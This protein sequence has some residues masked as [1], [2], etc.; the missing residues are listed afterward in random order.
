MNLIKGKSYSRKEISKTLGG[1]G[2]SYLPI[3]DGQI[4]CGC[5]KKD[6]N[7]DAPEEV[8]IGDINRKSAEIISEQEEP[9]PVFIKKDTDVWEYVGDYKCVD[10][11]IKPTLL[12][13]KEKQYPERGKITA[14]LKFKKVMFSN[15]GASSWLYPIAERTKRYFT[16]DDG[17]TEYVSFSSFSEAI[18]NQKFPKDNWWG[19]GQN[20]SKVKVGDEV[21]IYI[22]DENKGIVGYALVKGKQGSNKDTWKLCLNFDLDKCEQLIQKPISAKIVR[23]WIQGRIKTVNNLDTVL[24]KLEKELPWL[25]LPIFTAI[26]IDYPNPPGRVTS[27]ITRVIRDTKESKKL[28]KLYSDKCQ[29]CHTTLNLFGRNYSEA[30]HLQPLGKA[31]QGPDIQGNMLIVCP[32]HHAQLD[33]GAITIDPDTFEIAH[34]N[35]S[36]LGKL[37]VLPNHKLNK[38]YLKY[39]LDFY[40]KK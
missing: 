18:K 6:L 27:K 24:S 35:G 20:F 22:G 15:S 36:K 17:S 40:T 12:R 9:I 1:S 34:K 39:H 16:Y 10:Y 32:N 30:H 2:Q 38:R 37:I 14:V 23:Q 3:K 13:Q 11:S 33:Y 5:F 31:H 19:I 28:K 4:T 26:D 7:P 21:Y 29:V 8:L 25:T